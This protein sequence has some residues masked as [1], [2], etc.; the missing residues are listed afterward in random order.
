MRTSKILEKLG[1]VSDDTLKEIERIRRVRNNV[2]H[3]VEIPHNVAL[4]EAGLRIQAIAERIS[5][6]TPNL[7]R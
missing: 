4:R 3:G 5:R 1:S 7:N 6:D 2:V